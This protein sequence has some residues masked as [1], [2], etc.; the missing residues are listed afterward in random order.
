MLLELKVGLLGAIYFS[1]ADLKLA[2]LKLGSSS[3]TKTVCSTRKDN[4]K[5][6]PCVC[7]FL[8]LHRACC[9]DYFLY[10]NS[11]TYIHFKNTNSH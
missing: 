2:T 10:S 8:L 3:D 6:F 7:F 1:I 5:Q 4:N 11:C 9:Y